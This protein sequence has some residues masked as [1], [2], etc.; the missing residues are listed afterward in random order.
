[1]G[2]IR[3]EAQKGT[4]EDQNIHKQC[5]RCILNIWWPVKIRNEDLWQRGYQA[6]QA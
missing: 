1:M 5:L 4:T 6:P 2:Q 3:G